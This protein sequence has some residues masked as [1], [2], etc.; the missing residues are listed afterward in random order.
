MNYENTSINAIQHRNMVSIHL[1][2]TYQKIPL[3][4]RNWEP[5]AYPLLFPHATLGWGIPSTTGRHVRQHDEA[6]Q[7]WYYRYRLLHEHRFQI[8]GRLTNEYLVDMFSRN[9]ESRLSYIRSNQA[10]IREEDAALMG[11]GI[12]PDNENIYLPASFLGSN[13]WASEQIAD[14][15]AIAAEL[16]NPTFFITMTCNPEWPEI[17][18]QCRPGQNATDIPIVVAR[19][20]HQKLQRLLKILK[21]MF[22]NAGR[23][24]YIIYSVEFQK[25]GYPHVHILIKYPHSLTP[26]Q[27]DSVISAEMPTDS[28]DAVLVQKFMVH[29]HSASYCMQ[30]RTACRFHYPQQVRQSTE[31]AG[32]G[33]VLYRR[34]TDNDVDV[35]AHVMSILR[36]MICHINWECAAT[37]HLFQYLFKYIHKGDTPV[38]V[39]G[40][41]S[42]F[43]QDRTTRNMLSRTMTESMKLKTTG[44]DATSLVRRRHGEFLATIFPTKSQQSLLFPFTW[45]KHRTIT[46]STLTKTMLARFHISS[47]TFIAH[48]TFS[49]TPLESQR[50]L[51]HSPSSN[52]SNSSDYQLTIQPKIT[53]LPITENH[54]TLPEHHSTM[55]SSERGRI[56]MSH[57]CNLFFHRKASSSTLEPFFSVVPD[58]PLTTSTLWMVFVIVHIR[59]QPPPLASSHTRTKSSLLFEKL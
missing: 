2:G 3:L 43:Y 44:K 17:T 34:R 18:S 12:V 35:V 57:D 50:P 6:T 27:I 21:T 9:I 15:L 45:L 13:R 26:E 22:P 29:R 56:T 42:H 58:A 59:K 52:T 55:S 25:R 1:D 4:S 46:L 5:L 36:A 11:E 7:M 16:G 28:S 47:V 48:K 49:S 30:N 33:K 8:F 32:D 54:R 19:V 31:I 53:F 41:Q 51:T 37:S 38:S 24:V 20:F 40:H 23:P 14:A 39:Y 10:R